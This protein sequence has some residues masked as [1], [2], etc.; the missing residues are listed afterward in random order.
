MHSRSHSTFQAVAVASGSGSAGEEQPVVV[1]TALLEDAR[2]VRCT[3]TVGR[4][5]RRAL[6]LSSFQGPRSRFT[7]YA[8]ANWKEN[9]MPTLTLTVTLDV[10]LLCHSHSH[11][12]SHLSH[13]HSHSPS[14]LSVA[15]LTL[16]S[17]TCSPTP[18]APATSPPQLLYRDTVSPRTPSTNRPAYQVLALQ[19]VPA[20]RRRFLTYGSRATSPKPANT[21]SPNV[22][23][24]LL[25]RAASLQVPHNYFTHFYLVSVVSSLFWGWNLRLWDAAGHLP[26]VW[27]LMLGQGGRRLVESY[28][29]TSSSK[30]TM[31]FAH[32]IL[33]LLFYLATNMAVWVDLQSDL[34]NHRTSSPHG[35]DWKTALLVPAVLTAQMLQHLYHAY[36]YRLRIQNDG[37]QLP[38]H[39]LFPNLLCPHYTCDVAV[40]VLL[41]LL[42]APAGQ[43]VNWTLATAA[44]FT[45]VNLAVTAHGT[46]IWY[47]DKF[48][49]EK[50]SGRRRMIPGVW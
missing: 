15:S 40:Y 25:D 33:G 7:S 26:F 4:C 1:A 35:L 44:I 22:L 30:S 3:V 18:C 32:W 46:K 28:V 29:Y 45:A 38:S 43:A 12:P 42:G 2:Q 20:L 6:N 47:E 9:Y 8:R 5:D 48:G 37:Y 49:K 11:S 31:W 36:L 19:A 50:V 34:A 13:S 41:S 17:P 10:T 21:A 39:R 14:H 27:A 24:K 16:V 23:E